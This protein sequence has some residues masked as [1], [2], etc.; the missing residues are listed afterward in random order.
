MELITILN[1][2]HR[3]RG[4][5]YRH[6][7]FSA[8]KKSS[9]AAVR[10]RNGSAAVWSGCHLPASLS[11]SSLGNGVDSAAE[12][13]RHDDP[14]AFRAK[15]LICSRGSIPRFAKD[16]QLFGSRQA[17][18]HLPFFAFFGSWAGA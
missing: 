1:R 9:E 2:C 12:I 16:P 17:L 18:H 7:H 10:P 3:V 5:V 15:N 6:A 4:F 14:H 11:Y 8:D 13:V